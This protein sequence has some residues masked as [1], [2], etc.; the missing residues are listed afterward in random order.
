M[1]RA[2]RVARKAVAIP[3]LV[4]HKVAGILAPAVVAAANMTRADRVAVAI[5]APV[6]RRAAV[7]PVLVDRVLVLAVIPQVETR[8]RQAPAT[9]VASAAC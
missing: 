9:K 2:D 8:V 5:P 4:V 7:I 1:T 6:A 3:A